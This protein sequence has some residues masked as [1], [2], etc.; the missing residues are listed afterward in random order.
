MRSV[1]AGSHE[2]IGR[3][4]NLSSNENQTIARRAGHRQNDAAW[5][6]PSQGVTFCPR[7][8]AL[9]TRT[10]LAE[11]SADPTLARTPA[12]QPVAAANAGM[13]QSIDNDAS[14]TSY[15]FRAVGTNRTLN[16]RERLQMG[17]RHTAAN[18]LQR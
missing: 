3:E 13:G 16:Q 9:N 12:A 7:M 6:P 2:S 1:E 5:V 11:M 4:S 18:G 15:N 17:C 8:P 10:P 14:A